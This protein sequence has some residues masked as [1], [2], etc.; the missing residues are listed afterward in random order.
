[1]YV[2]I[3]LEPY[4]LQSLILLYN[5]DYKAVFQVIKD[6]KRTM[7]SYVTGMESL[8]GGVFLASQ[9]E[10]LDLLIAKKTHK[11]LKPQLMNQLPRR[12]YLDQT[13]QT[14]ITASNLDLL[15]KRM[16]QLAVLDD[17]KNQKMLQYLNLLEVESIQRAFVPNQFEGI[18]KK[19]ISKDQNTMIFNNDKELWADEID[20]TQAD[21]NL[22][23]SKT[24]KTL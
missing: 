7:A 19:S 21:I 22:C 18:A 10:A 3:D 13:I 11:A 5:C 14:A 2:D 8:S 20:K 23:A 16:T 4:L 12:F 6:L 17:Q 15:K 1:M 9:S 24:G